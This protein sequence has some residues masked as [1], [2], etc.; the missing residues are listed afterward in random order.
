MTFNDFN[1]LNNKIESILQTYIGK[2]DRE[3]LSARIHVKLSPS[4]MNILF[5]QHEKFRLDVSKESSCYCIDVTYH[6]KSPRMEETMGC[7]HVLK[8]V[9]GIFT[10]VTKKDTE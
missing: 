6:R 4:Y 1:E 7:V 2:N 9:D 5:E 8:F 10:E 3:D